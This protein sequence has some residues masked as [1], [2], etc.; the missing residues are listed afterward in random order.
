MLSELIVLARDRAPSDT[1]V[2]KVARELVSLA[3]RDGL[4]AEQLI[5]AVKKEW[6]EITG[7]RRSAPEDGLR[8]TQERLISECIR[9][10]Y[11][12]T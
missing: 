2:A 7:P 12:A 4:Q 10:F 5:V 6:V 3:H 9:S 8:E 11:D 1:A